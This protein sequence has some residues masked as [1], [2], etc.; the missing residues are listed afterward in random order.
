[1][2]F[3]LFFG[4]IGFL[5]YVL[6]SH[7]GAA[8]PDFFWGFATIL[9]AL[10]VTPLLMGVSRKRQ[11]HTLARLFALIGFTWLGGLFL[12]DCVLGVLA[13]YNLLAPFI[14]VPP[15]SAPAT[16]WTSATI[17]LAGIA[18]GVIEARAPR[19][20]T[21]DLKLPKISGWASPIRIVQLTDLHLGYVANAR[22]LSD[23]VIRVNALKPDLIVSTG[24]LFDSD[25]DRM[26]PLCRILADLHAPL[27]KFAISGNHEV[28]ENLDQGLALTRQ[29]GFRIL[30]GESARVRSGLTIVGV[31]DAEALK[32]GTS[33]GHEAGALATIHENDVRILLKHRPTV[34]RASLGKFDLQLSGHTHGGQIFPFSL[35]TRM[36]YR[37]GP[38]LNRLGENAWLYLSRGTGTWGPQFR[39]FAPPEITLITLSGASQTNPNK[40]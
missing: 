9:S 1:M 39:I 36:V 25:F 3:I 5:H 32:P 13:L 2:F 10:F 21:V 26:T 31:D 38:G 30:R 22:R 17:T 12:W 16:V 27:G 40:T 19:V 28:Y 18:Y 7:L 11:Q 35:L 23:L 8:W 6:L 37:H 14:E 24:D 34:L 29:A 33:R 15:L 20:K 4:I